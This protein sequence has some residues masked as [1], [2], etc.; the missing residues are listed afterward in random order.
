MNVDI[1]YIWLEN[2]YPI[3]SPKL[4]FSEDLNPEMGSNV[5][6]TKKGTSLHVVYGHAR[7]L[8]YQS[9]TKIHQ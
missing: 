8:N 9:C 1:W 7:R 6:E 4:G 3:M 2:A 5:N